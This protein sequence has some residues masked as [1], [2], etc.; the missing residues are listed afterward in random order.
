MNKPIVWRWILCLFLCLTITLGG[1]FIM[2]LLLPISQGI[3]YR[4]SYGD[5]T[6]TLLGSI[7]IGTKEM[8]KWNPE[9]KDS[10]ANAEVIVMECDTSDQEVLKNINEQ[11]C[12]PEGENLADYLSKNTYDLLVE[13]C[14]KNSISLSTVENQFPWAVINTLTVYASSKQMGNTQ[15]VQALR[16]GVEA[17]VMREK[18]DAEYEYLETVQAQTDAMSGFS[19]ELQDYLVAVVCEQLITGESKEQ[20]GLWPKWW[21][22]G[23]AKAFSDEY[24]SGY[25]QT[26]EEY[27]PLIEE[28]HQKL[29]VERNAD[30]VEQ[31]EQYLLTGDKEKYFV[32]VG[33]LHLVLENENIIDKLEQKGYQVEKFPL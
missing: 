20:Q 32:V 22:E 3:A 31:L 12:L 1:Y 33:L 15:L 24:W 18:K 19:E 7:H 30:M 6:M 9:L 25:Y 28:Y 10:L 29:I 26:A 27:K 8:T 5:K 4:I 21:Q 17:Q 14:G 11:K 2:E 23:N 16:Y 13:A